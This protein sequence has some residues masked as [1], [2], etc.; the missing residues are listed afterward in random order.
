MHLSTLSG[1]E[2][3][4]S[5][6]HQQDACCS[7]QRNKELTRASSVFPVPG[8]PTR[9]APLGMWAPSSLYLPGV[10]RKLTNSM[11]SVLASS[12]PAT[13]LNMVLFLAFLSSTCTCTWAQGSVSSASVAGH[14]STSIGAGAAG[15]QHRQQDLQA[16]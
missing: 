13:S 9:R 1:R 15:Q 7:K 2:L 10:L 16:C 12:Q 6:Q 14:N 5:L 4:T 11:I 8:G 3:A